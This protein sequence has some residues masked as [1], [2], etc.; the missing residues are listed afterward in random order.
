M[1][2][3]LFERTSLLQTLRGNWNE[4]IK[5]GSI[6]NENWEEKHV[7]RAILNRQKEIDKERTA[8]AWRNIFVKSGIIK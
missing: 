1:K 8:A 4:F 7:K 5:K 3:L 6:K 2:K